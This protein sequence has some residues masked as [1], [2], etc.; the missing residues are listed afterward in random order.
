MSRRARAKR[1]SL[2]EGDD[3]I[4]LRSRGGGATLFRTQEEKRPTQDNGR[5]TE[6]GEGTSGMPIP[7]LETSADARA[8]KAAKKVEGLVRDQTTK[9]VLD[10]AD[11]ALE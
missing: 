9:S 7:P 4:P 11:K 2:F 8:A 10:I 6:G 1:L 5:V 3:E